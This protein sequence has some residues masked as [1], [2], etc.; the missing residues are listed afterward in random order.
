MMNDREHCPSAVWV[1][2]QLKENWKPA[3]FHVA[4]VAERIRIWAV[5]P[6]T[7][8]QSRPHS[9]CFVFQLTLT[10]ATCSMD[11]G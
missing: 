3:K 4:T 5:E 10:R 1:G 7:C 8:A 2:E 6:M 11:I 9:D